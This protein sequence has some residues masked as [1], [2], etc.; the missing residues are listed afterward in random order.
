MPWSD[1]PLE[2]LR[3]YRSSVVRPPDF[4]KFW[5][6]TLSASRVKATPPRL[7]RIDTRMPAVEVFDVTFS[8]FEGHPVRAWLRRPTGL[9][10]P[11][12]VIVQFL[13]YSGGRGLAHQV[14]PWVLRGYAVLTMDTRG[15]GAGGGYEGATPDPV[16]TGP[17]APGFMSR[18]I[19]SPHTYYYRRVM[20]DAVLAVD[21]VR[22]IDGLDPDAVAVMGTSQGGG[23]ALAVAGLADGVRAVMA[24][25]PF[26]CDFPRAIGIAANG[27]YQE[28]T[29][30]LASR[31][32]DVERVLRTLSYFD[33]TVF[34]GRA[35]APAMFSVA[36]CDRIC[37]PSTV[38]AAYA[39]YAGE[40]RMEIYP[41]NDHEGGTFHQEARELDWLPGIVP[42]P[43]DIPR[44]AARRTTNQA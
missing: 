12:P 44:A 43:A 3:A 28:L 35:G 15:Q 41:Y 29:A 22:R 23:L 34:A 38:F 37:P 36:L 11:L 33:G 30:L 25:V 14:G 10:G 19:E 7:D 26:L 32:N 2:D 1:L 40:K 4:E 9:K 20:T 6:D 8:G 16:G 27:P 5:T 18:G 13:G 31:R 24:N 21:A 17:S 42:T 39:A